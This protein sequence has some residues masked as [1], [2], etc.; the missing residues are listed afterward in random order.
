MYLLYYDMRFF[1]SVTIF[2][3]R[4]LST[5]IKIKGGLQYP[6][7]SSWCIQGVIFGYLFLIIRGEGNDYAITDFLNLDVFCFL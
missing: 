4:N 3:I 5:I 2:S 7:L 6:I 1:L